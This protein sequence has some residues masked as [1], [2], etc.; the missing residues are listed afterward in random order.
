MF[1]WDDGALVEPGILKVHFLVRTARNG[2]AL[3]AIR[4]PWEGYIGVLQ[5]ELD[6]IGEAYHLQ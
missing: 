6:R 3:F 4:S 2:Q 5:D 1:T